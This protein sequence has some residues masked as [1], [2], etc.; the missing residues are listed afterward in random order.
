MEVSWN[1]GTPTSSISN[2]IFH[3]TIYIH[4]WKPPIVGC[5]QVLRQRSFEQN[6]A[7]KV[8]SSTPSGF[9]PGSKWGNSLEQKWK[10]K[11]SCIN[12]SVGKSALNGHVFL[13]S[14]ATKWQGLATANL[15]F[16]SHSNF[17]QPSYS[18]HW[19]EWLVMPVTLGGFCRIQPCLSETNT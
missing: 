2:G 10:L 18:S 16:I 4:L 8:P 13:D 17:L 1:R 15:F 5:P 14:N 3:T 9:V 19:K 6:R 11:L 7:D 12:G